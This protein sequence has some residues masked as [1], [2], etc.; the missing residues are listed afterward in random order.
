MAAKP[1]TERHL[2]SV[3]IPTQ[4]SEKAVEPQALTDVSKPSYY[5]TKFSPEAG[6]YVLNYL[7]PSTP[8]TKVVDSDRPGGLFCQM[9]PL[10]SLSR[11]FARLSFRFALAQSRKRARLLSN[12]ALSPLHL[13]L[14]II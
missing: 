7:G 2:F 4:S 10:Y 13:I 6:F 5:A 9:L 11:A 12:L 8:W 3:P 1:S 14:S